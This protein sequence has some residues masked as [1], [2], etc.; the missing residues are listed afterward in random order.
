MS[1]SGADLIRIE[2]QRQVSVEQYTAEHDAG[3]T[4]ELISAAKVYADHSRFL[5][6][7]P[8]AWPPA[9]REVINTPQEWPW[10][11]SYYKPS[12]DPIRDLTKAGALIAA[13]LDVLIAEAQS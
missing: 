4:A 11:G 12:G 1:Q 6:W 3:H 10:D 9:A 13:A 5:V 7:H 2:R 8:G